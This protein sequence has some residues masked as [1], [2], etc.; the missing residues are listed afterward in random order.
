MD[1]RPPQPP[2]G[3]LIADALERSGLS[4]RE[5]SKRAGISYGRW[6]QISSGYQNVSPGS[7][8]RVTAPARTLARMAAVVNVSADEM[9]EAGRED[10]AQ[11]MREGA[12]RH[13]S[14]VPSDGAPVEQAMN[15]IRRVEG[16]TEDEVRAFEM[17]ARGMAASRAGEE[18]NGSRRQA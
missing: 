13:L 6:R 3:K 7:W 11:V 5:A 15:A 18:E 4:I 14:A 10:V 17:L 1:E 16:L 12:S 2:E 9:A 8:A